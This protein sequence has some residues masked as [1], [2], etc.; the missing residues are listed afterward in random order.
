[1]PAYHT[2]NNEIV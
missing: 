1:M 2:H